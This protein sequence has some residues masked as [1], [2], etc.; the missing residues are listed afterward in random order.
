MMCETAAKQ[1]EGMEGNGGGLPIQWEKVGF[2]RMCTALGR[3]P[4]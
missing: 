2:G 4:A 1:T 3:F